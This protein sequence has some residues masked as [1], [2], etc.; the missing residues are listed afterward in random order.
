MAGYQLQ[1]SRFH[2]VFKF[3]QAGVIEPSAGHKLYGEQSISLVVENVQGNNEIQLQGKLADSSD[4]VT[5][6]EVKGAVFSGSNSDP[7]I[8]NISKYDFIR[9]NVT[10]YSPA[11]GTQ[12]LLVASGFYSET[13]GNIDSA[14][15]AELKKVNDHLITLNCNVKSL[16]DAMSRLEHHMRLI[17]GLDI[18]GD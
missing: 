8:F 12:P 9:F 13:L 16:T 11:I 7:H 5:I 18:N 15:T 14:E 17:T 10:R 2:K 4:W 1:S 3:T 6:G